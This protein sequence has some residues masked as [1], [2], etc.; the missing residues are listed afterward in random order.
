MLRIVTDDMM[1]V[2][3]DGSKGRETEMHI[4]VKYGLHTKN[5]DDVADCVKSSKPI[6]VTL[7]KISKFDSDK[8]YDVLKID[9]RSNQLLLIPN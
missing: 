6:E 3:P 4:T 7:G 1:Y 2:E 8:Y 9:I 5:P